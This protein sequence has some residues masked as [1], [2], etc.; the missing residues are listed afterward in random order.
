MIVGS[1][2]HPAITRRPG[3]GACAR[4]ADAEPASRV[5]PGDRPAPRPDLHQID[6]RR[7]DRISAAP[8]AAGARSRR[9]PDLV[10]LCHPGRP[11]QDQHG[12]GRGAAPKDFAERPDAGG[13]AADIDVVS[14]IGDVSEQRPAAEYGSN[15]RDV[16]Q[17]N[18]AG[19][20]VV[21]DQHVPGPQ[22]L[23][24]IPAD[25]A[26]DQLHK[27]AQ[28][29]RLR[30]CLGGDPK[31]TIKKRAREIVPGL[32]VRRVG[33]APQRQRHFLRDLV[34]GVADHLE[35]H[36]IDLLQRGP[37]EDF[38]RRAGGEPA[39]CDINYRSGATM[40]WSFTRPIEWNVKR[41]VADEHALH[42][43]L[44]GAGSPALNIERK[45]DLAV[46]E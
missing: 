16:V 20:R 41:A 11:A 39:R 42:H 38:A 30:K 6:H 23:G 36:G 46:V 12:L 29:H 22:P 4:G 37:P 3:V 31:V 34:Q 18:P 43:A 28:V 7:A 9:G 15:H 44:D 24:P 21:C 26:G 8:P 35:P 1:V 17:V 5:D 32:D 25:G 14:E 40:T 10:V 27:R 33:A 2:A 19:V 45:H 13:R